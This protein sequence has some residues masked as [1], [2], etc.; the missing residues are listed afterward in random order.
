MA[1]ILATQQKLIEAIFQILTNFKKDGADRKTTDYIN[2]RISSLDSYW[3]E[4]NNNH[5]Q[6]WACQDKSHAYFTENQ[7]EKTKATYENIKTTLQSYEPSA[8]ARPPT[9]SIL[10]PATPL[11]TSTVPPALKESRGTNSK[12]ED[13]LKKQASNFR[14]FH[15]TTSNINIDSVTEKWELEDLLHSLQSRWSAIDNLHWE[16]DSEIQGTSNNDYERAF[17]SY[18]QMYNT[19]KRSINSKLWSVSHR[20]KSTPQMDIPTFV[21]NY[22]QWTSFKDLFL[23]TIHNNPSLS[24]AQKM[25][26][27]KGKVR[28]EAERLLQHLPISSENYN[29]CWE[30][31]NHRYN[32]KKLI[33]TSHINNLLTIPAMQQ[34]SLNQLKRLH[35]TTL[36]AL[37]A[38]KNLG[39]DISTWDPLLVH[40]LS[41]KLDN[42]SFN[43]YNECLEQPR[44]LPTLTDFLNFLEC[45][46]TTMESSRRKQ[47]QPSARPQVYQ[48]AAKQNKSRFQV[49]SNNNTAEQANMKNY[50][51]RVCP[52]CNN[53]HGIYFCEKFLSMSP[54]QKLNT[55]SRLKMCSNCLFNHHGNCTSQKRCRECQ[56]QHNTILHEAFAT[57]QNASR[58]STSRM[59]NH[60]NS[61]TLSV[62]SQKHEAPEILLATAIVQ[63]QAANGHYFH[64]RAL[65]DQGSQTSIITEK[66]AQ[67]LSL[68]RRQ[69]KGVIT[70]IGAKENNCKGI[71]NITIKSNNNEY[72]LNTDALIMKTLINNLPSQTLSR[73]SWTF[74]E[75]IQL[76]DPEFYKSRPV[77]LLLGAEVYSNIILD[78][79]CRENNQTPIAQQTRFGWILSGSAN[80]TALQ[81][82]VLLNNIE[83]IQR[84][85]QIEDITQETTLSS[86]DQACVD[87][88]KSTTIRRED[89]RYE[90]KLPLKSNFEKELGTSKH[91]AIA[92]FTQLEQKFAKQNDTANNYKL[93]INEYL[94]SGHMKPATGNTTPDYFLPHHCVL[95]A[96]SKTTALRVVFNA[97]AK[98]STGLSLNDLMYRGPNLQQDLQFLILKWRQYKYAYTADIEKMFRQ[99]W[100]SE[101][102][103]QYHKIVWR[104]NQA[105]PIQEYQLSTVTYGTK[106]A[107]FL[108]MMTLK[109]L[110]DDEKHNYQESKAATVLRDSFYMDDL[111]HGSH[112]LSSAI[113][114][115]NDLTKLLKSGGFNLRK[116]SSNAPELIEDPSNKESFDFRGTESTKALGLRWNPQDDSFTFESKIQT[117][118]SKTTKRTLLSAISTIFDP[119]GWLSPVTIKLKL[120]FQSTWISNIDWNDN[121]PDEINSEWHKIKDD[122]Q[123]INKIKIQRWL[124]TQENDVI[125]LHGFCDASTKAYACVVYCKITRDGQSTVVLVAGKTRLVPVSKTVTLPRLELCGAVLLSQLMDK[126]IQG[127]PNYQIKMYGWTDSTAVLGWLRGDPN[128]WKTFVANRVKQVTEVLPG[129][130]WR[131]VKSQDNPADCASRGLTA[132]Q[133]EKHS[134]WWQG[135]SW[136]ISF[137][138]KPEQVSYETKEELKQEKQVNTSTYQGDNMSIIDEIIQKYSTI[139]KIVHILA[140]IY[141]FKSTVQDKKQQPSYLTLE[142]IR[143][144][145]LK[146]IKHVQQ[147][148]FSREIDD[149]KASTFVNSKSKIL[150]LNPQLDQDGLLRVGGRLRYA[151]MS[152][153]MKHPIII[154]HSSP[155]TDLLIDEAH[156]LTYHGGAR[157]TASFLRQRYWIVGGNR[158]IKKRL[159]QCVRC[160]RY[161]TVKQHQIMGDLPQARS[162]PSRPFCH[163][164]VDFT[165]HI[166]IKS[167]KGRGIKCTKG[168]VAVF[169]CMATKAV[170][171]ELV[172]D[173]T[174]SAFLA[175]LK[176]MAARRGKPDH[177]YSDNGTNFVGANKVIQQEYEILQATINENNSAFMQEITDMNIRWSFNAPFWSSA[178]GLWEGAV[179]S[180]KYHLKRVVGEQKLT[181][182]EFSTIL[183]QLEGCLNARPLCALSED[184]E[185]LD[186]LTPSHF[187]A[188]GPVLSLFETEHDL[189]TRWYLCQKIYNDIWKRWRAEYLSQLTIRSKW[190]KS[191]ENIKIND[192]VIIHEDNLPAGR[193]GMGRVV[194]LHPGSDGYVRVVTLKTKKGYLKRPIVKLSLL[195]INQNSNHDHKQ[196]NTASTSD[197]PKTVV[198]HKK[199]HRLQ[200]KTLAL[201]MLYFMSILTTSSCNFINTQLKQNQGIY[202]DKV[203]DMQVIRDDWTVVVYYKM[204]PY[205]QGMKTFERYY[206]H[207]EDTCKTLNEQVN[208]DVI[209]WQLRHGYNELQH[210]NT[211]LMTQHSSTRARRRRGLINAVG[212]VANSLFGVLDEKF[213]EQYQKDITLIH[214]NQQHLASLWRNQTSIVEAEYN[215]LKRSEDAINKQNKLVNKH[216]LKIE[217]AVNILNAEVNNI[218]QSNYMALTAVAASNM[219]HELRNI[220]ESLLDTVTDVY[221]GRFNFHLLSPEQLRNEL[222]VIA[223][224]ISNELT[225]PIENIHT[226]V[227][228]IYHLLNIKARMCNDYLLFEIKVPLVSRDSFEIFHLIPVPTATN[229]SKMIDTVPISEYLAVSLAKDAYI[230][231][232]KEDVASCQQQ[233]KTYLCQLKKPV[234]HLKQEES[235]CDYDI[236]KKQCKT[237][238]RPCINKWVELN[239]LNK[240]LY[241]CCEKCQLRVICADQVTAP[242]LEQAGLVSISH[243]CIV[244]SDLFTVHTR[245]LGHNIIKTSID[246]KTQDISPINNIINASIPITPI[247]DDTINDRQRQLSDIEKGLKDLKEQA[248]LSTD[249]SYHDVHQY[250]L[251]YIMIGIGVIVGAWLVW[252]RVRRARP[253]AVAAPP[254]AERTTVRL[255][256]IRSSTCE[257]DDQNTNKIHSVQC[258]NKSTSPIVTSNSSLFS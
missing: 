23:E 139:K 74:L 252:R 58:P 31:L 144:S 201:A 203:S 254:A 151:E 175:A 60:S 54:Q 216:L 158:A 9:P 95:R 251:I 89:G 70:G 183:S 241:F 78:G 85:W 43:D 91:K 147:E 184:P 182:E 177:I 207:L 157:L 255:S 80:S 110:A 206:H 83:D 229:H 131:Y 162:N 233:E 82:N 150:N 187:L 230:T 38:V 189:R 50:Q 146:I 174:T 168:Y 77:D 219:I 215:V 138:D 249:V 6:L 141:R 143:S 222:R 186:C 166:M 105:K 127:L 37:N 223:S 178:G 55:V 5:L 128:K 244:K 181:Y 171:L 257:D 191:Q 7:Y 73:P 125:E 173:L 76:A 180:L 57:S 28:G 213:A 3:M 256:S 88:Y 195:P 66:A 235:L 21:G 118:Q 104:D 119:L 211:I 11:G 122:I 153:D 204:E 67:L 106:A 137:E 97:S 133:L 34:Q 194:E 210:Y 208:C 25:Q 108:A 59:A 30:I 247:V 132:S 26:F 12:T 135:P 1:D 62:P 41:Q 20:E 40:L 152:S 126:V 258:K 15:R 192:L 69:C 63:V 172:S 49:Y 227:Q 253:A 148:Y 53:S 124:E 170:H 111:I 238:I 225:L 81:C 102:H 167:S 221:H 246:I 142:E 48:P 159:R 155:L 13:L 129:G 39:I 163:T 196:T 8:E 243:G 114:L 84:F 179:K 220:Q 45:K 29:I 202:F 2:R 232:K 248:V 165:G 176:R 75:N 98:T 237:V 94:T 32:N 36:E 44:E 224:Q 212:S 27:L 169:V 93:F 140:W 136:L 145:K 4:F 100:L 236:D 250:A 56:G 116:W 18:E 16:I 61:S 205:W 156:A 240:Y 90:V 19:I 113:Q 107:P 120:L 123:N 228:N 47:D 217:N 234:Y 134:M 46:F 96:E 115:K 200:F 199:Q 92:Q 68:P 231:M 103:Q 99:I 242:Q 185:D 117:N 161:D 52:L 33:F 209:L 239:T 109:Q 65:L 72:S 197:S 87:Y 188:S 10:K 24:N 86:E 22:H 160:R 42:E 79:I 218:S 154:P 101:E 17:S 226:N 190:M 51:V 130:N 35:D 164:G 14:A 245:N 64:L 149:L 198:K 214:D 121:L 193:W 71:I 112:S